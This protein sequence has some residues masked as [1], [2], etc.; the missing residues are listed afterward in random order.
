MCRQCQRVAGLV[1]LGKVGQ[2][3]SIDYAGSLESRLQR[4]GQRVAPTSAVTVAQPH[5]DEGKSCDSAAVCA[6]LPDGTP[7]AEMV[8]QHKYY[9]RR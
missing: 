5:D 7:R 2:L 1:N 3:G 6:P 9:L 4:W 8:D